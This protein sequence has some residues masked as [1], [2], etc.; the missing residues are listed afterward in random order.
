MRSF[1]SEWHEPKKSAQVLIL[2]GEV[3][4]PTG[5]APDGRWSDPERPRVNAVA[6]ET[7]ERPARL[8]EDFVQAVEHTGEFF[9]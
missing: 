9:F 2:S 6:L 4:G 8:S 5:V 3:S 7:A 1:V